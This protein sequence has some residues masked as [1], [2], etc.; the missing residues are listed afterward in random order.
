ME[1]FE[2]SIIDWLRIR[3][4]EED[5]EPREDM[6]SVPT[7]T[8]VGSWERVEVYR[9][10]VELGLKIWNPSDSTVATP[11]PA[12]ANTQREAGIRIVSTPISGRKRLGN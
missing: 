12:L 10:R 7:D 9:R 3:G 2:G 8:V 6:L 4:Y 5:Y 11:G 1:G